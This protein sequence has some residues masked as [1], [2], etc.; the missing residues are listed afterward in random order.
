MRKQR[1]GHRTFRGMD[2][3]CALGD[4]VHTSWSTAR[5]KQ[6]GEKHSEKNGSG[7][8]QTKSLF[9]NFNQTRSTGCMQQAE[10]N[11]TSIDRVSHRPLQ[12][13]ETPVG[14]GSRNQRQV[15]ILRGNGGNGD[16]RTYSASCDTK[17]GTYQMFDNL[18]WAEG[19]PAVLRTIPHDRDIKEV[20]PDRVL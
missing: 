7:L 13:T 3:Y 16:F 15:W 18:I 2:P 5:R 8:R 6:T 1:R 11:P 4:H 20:W 14:V 10:E 17:K 12:A 19:T 9:R